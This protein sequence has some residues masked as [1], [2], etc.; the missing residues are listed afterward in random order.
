MKGGE[1]QMESE[2]Q[3]PK[4]SIS[5]TVKSE[6]EDREDFESFRNAVIG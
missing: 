1:V 4:G 5:E 6:E 3:A 2:T